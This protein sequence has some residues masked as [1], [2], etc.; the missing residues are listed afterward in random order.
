MREGRTF[1]VLVPLK[2]K[3]ENIIH[4]YQIMKKI[5]SLI[6]LVLMATLSLNAKNYKF[7]MNHS[8][9]VQVVRVAQQGTKF[10]KVWGVAGSADKAMVQAMQ[11]A[12][13]A[14]IFTGVEGNENAG[15]VPALTAGRSVYEEHKDFFDK[16]FTKGEF[17][18][19]VKNSNTGYPTGENN[20]AVSGG[21]KVGL[22]VVVMYD[23]LRKRLEDEGIVKKLDSYF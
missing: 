19:Y 6:V 11:D 17:L 22:F 4:K 7:D 8:Y 15:K 14:C 5:T 3:E 2:S 9:E 21:R 12:V 18:N 10:L 13:A 1:F 20:R 23:N 16:F